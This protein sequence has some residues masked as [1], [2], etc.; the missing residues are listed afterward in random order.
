MPGCSCPIE[1]AYLGGD[2]SG[3]IFINGKAPGDA[4]T[5][6]IGAASEHLSQGIAWGDFWLGAAVV[7]VAMTA[8]VVLR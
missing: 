5:G 4:F 7:I 6:G 1:N 3:C 8:T 2:K